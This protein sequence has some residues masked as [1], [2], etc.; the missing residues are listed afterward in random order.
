MSA[1]IDQKLQHVVLAQFA[2]RYEAEFAAGFLDDAEIPY[3]LQVDDAAMGML[4]ATPATLWVLGMDLQR[5][6]DVLDLSEQ[7]VMDSPVSTESESAEPA[8]REAV[9][10]RE[11]GGKLDERLTVLER[12]LA[13]TFVVGGV[14]A[15][16]FVQAGPPGPIRAG[17]IFALVAPMGVGVLFGRTI[18]PIRRLLRALSGSAP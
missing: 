10:R 6:R 13:L 3:R 18:S 12:A 15:G 14:G 5:A 8:W 2:Y 16:W 11:D 9:I 7:A 17:I 4:I 1:K